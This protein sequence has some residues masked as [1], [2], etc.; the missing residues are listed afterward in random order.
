MTVSMQ[1]TAQSHDIS[2]ATATPA[3]RHRSRASWRHIGEAARPGAA[4]S[5]VAAS[6]P[7]LKDQKHGNEAHEQNW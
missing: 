7:A 5:G 6:R 4:H 3:A 1:D 2:T